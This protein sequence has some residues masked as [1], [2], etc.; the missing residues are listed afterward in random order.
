MFRRAGLQE[1]L[2]RARVPKATQFAFGTTLP[3][4]LVSFLRFVMSHN[5]TRSLTNPT[6]T[7]QSKTT[8][9]CYT[10]NNGQAGAPYVLKSPNSQNR[11]GVSEANYTEHLHDRYTDLHSGL[12]LCH[13][14][15][16]EQGRR[17]LGQHWPRW[18]SLNASCHSTAL[19]S[20]RQRFHNMYFHGSWKMLFLTLV[21]FGLFMQLQFLL[22]TFPSLREFVQYHILYLSVVFIDLE[23]HVL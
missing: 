11:G 1:T 10:P 23:S 17:I 4:L 3:I 7:V 18:R 22:V 19:V 16:Q 14:N 8:S 15:L 20:E 21:F 5:I 12:L 9:S 6:D 13:R 2:I